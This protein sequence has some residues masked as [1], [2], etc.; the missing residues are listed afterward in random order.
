MTVILSDSIP[1][2]V[3]FEGA[4]ALTQSLLSHME[5]GKIPKSDI[6]ATIQKLVSTL[7]GARGFFVSY[8]TDDRPF[9]DRPS[10]QT[11]AAL[12]TSEEIVAE[13]LVK[14]LAMSSAMVL[15]HRRRNDENMAK[16]SQR[17]RERSTQLIASLDLPDFSVKLSELLA[18]AQTGKGTYQSFLQ[19]WNYDDEQLLAIAQAVAK[20][21]ARSN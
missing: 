9:A 11:L 4:I 16:Q 17:V 5:Q 12:A 21:K 1:D 10:K 8:L 19:R 7:P 6:F 3:T 13:L 18:T 15:T 20:V 2:H 14:N